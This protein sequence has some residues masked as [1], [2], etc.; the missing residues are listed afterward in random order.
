MELFDAI[1][2]RHTTNGAFVD[3]PV[4]VEDKRRLLEMAARAPSHFNSQP[5]RFIVVEDAARRSQ[6]GRIAGESMRRLIEEGTFWQQ[7]KRYFRFT[8][9]EAS[10]TNDGIL[11]DNMPAV[12]KPFV[13]QLFTERGERMMNALQVPRVLANDARK[14]VER[15]PLLLGITLTRNEY[16]PGELS[17]LYSLVSL[18]A[19][20]Q[21]IWLTATSLG[22]GMQFVS[23]PQEIPE[24]WATIS[25]MLGVPDDHELMLLFRLGYTDASIKRPTIDWTSPQRKSLAELVFQEEWGNGL[26]G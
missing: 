21:T 20:V 15:S 2:Q 13:K 11:I 16:R 4:S 3:K 1:R 7:Y 12:L 26:D 14:L 10:A 25:R 19:V 8:P 6:I 24:N 18:G 23:T 22:M 9:E 5:W 17:A